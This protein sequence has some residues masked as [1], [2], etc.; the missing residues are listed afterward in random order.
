MGVANPGRKANWQN[1]QNREPD[2]LRF[3]GFG[4]ITKE[5]HHLAP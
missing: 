4:K 2:P 5:A 1:Y 3:A